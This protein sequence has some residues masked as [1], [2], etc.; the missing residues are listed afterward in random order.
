MKSL[1]FRIIILILAFAVQSAVSQ[2]S[3]PD[4]STIS[5]PADSVKIAAYDSVKVAEHDSAKIYTVPASAGSLF[6]SPDSHSTISRAEMNLMHYRSLSGILEQYPGV[7]MRNQYSE[8]QYD[9]ITIR[10]NDWRSVALMMDGRL[11][12]DPASGIYNPY[13][14]S[15]AYADRIE[16]VTGPRSFLYGLN[17]TG[18]AINIVT[19]NLSL[20]RPFS[21]LNYAESGYNYSYAD[22]TFSQNIGRKFNMMLGFQQQSTDG[23]FENS[24]S[25]QWNARI[26]LRYSI[27]EN[28]HVTVSEYFTH[29][30]TGLN[31][32]IDPTS[33]APAFDPRLATVVNS[34][35]YEKVSRH[36]VNASLIGSFFDDPTSIST[37]TFYYSHNSREY[38]DEENRQNPNGIFIQTDE[39]SSWWGAT[40]KQDIATKAQRLGLA[41]NVEFQKKS[42]YWVEVSNLNLRILEELMLGRVS[43]GAYA[44]IDKYS[45]RWSDRSFL[46][47]GGD[48][49][50]EISSFMNFFSGISSSYRLPSSREQEI[51]APNSFP[52]ITEEHHVRA[53][54]GIRIATGGQSIDLSFFHSTIDDPLIISYDESYSGDQEVINGFS[55]KLLL[56]FEWIEFDLNALYFYDGSRKWPRISGTGGIFYHNTIINGNLE[57]KSGFRGRYLSS[58][59]GSPFDAQRLIYYSPTSEA[60]INNGGSVDFETTAHIG[61][62]YV[63]F[64]WE[65]L[66]STQYFVTPYYPVLDR[67]IRFGI[68]W[69]FL[70]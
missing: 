11:L 34:D 40:L 26:K 59:D 43:I 14:F 52:R 55:C 57:L 18:G 12:N 25:E 33:L 53:E 15:T 17:S 27:L 51:R 65:N 22:G 67:E 19:P 49:Q 38:R 16:I 29:T 60:P 30:Q 62:A 64:T 45:K 10:G 46:G 70:D 48:I 2:G 8:G 5:V 50:V 58:Y 69:Q 4:S 1:H 31:G 41:A 54:A 7:F 47:Y 39:I 24:E 36:D 37:F 35:S 63:T 66:A 44:R 68:S 9:G 21:V 42:P 56:R 32:G 61:D 23:R 3:S 20:T 28:L 6:G 13:Y